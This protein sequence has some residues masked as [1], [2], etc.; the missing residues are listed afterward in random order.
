MYRIWSTGA[1]DVGE[2]PRFMEADE[3]LGHVNLNLPRN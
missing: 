1:K 3:A 2:D